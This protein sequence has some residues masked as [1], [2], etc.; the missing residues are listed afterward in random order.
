M[1]RRLSGMQATNTNRDSEA[2]EAEDSENRLFES[3]VQELILESRAASSQDCA[4]EAP[5]TTVEVPDE[6]RKLVRV[7]VPSWAVSRRSAQ[8]PRRGSATSSTTKG[9]RTEC[10]SPRFL[11]CSAS[12]LTCRPI[13]CL[14]YQFHSESVINNEKVELEKELVR[15]LKLEDH[16]DHKNWETLEADGYATGTNY[17]PNTLNPIATNQLESVTCFC[18]WYQ[19]WKKSCERW[20]LNS[21][22]P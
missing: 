6:R 20:S 10:S 1:K 4:G 16:S 5:A 22:T 8:Q 12:R 7:D 18:R 19:A 21:T 14:Q 17:G 2:G 13:F 3:E 15:M 9:W 11:S